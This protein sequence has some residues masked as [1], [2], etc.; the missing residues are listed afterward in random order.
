MAKYKSQRRWPIALVAAAVVLTGGIGYT[1]MSGGDDDDGSTSREPLTVQPASAQSAQVDHVVADADVAEGGL[2]LSV[3]DK[4]K[5]NSKVSF[6]VTWQADG[7]T[8]SGDVDLQAI[9]NKKWQSVKTIAVTDGSGTG[10]AKVPQAGLYRVA[11]GGGDDLDAT[12]SPDV[13][14]LTGGPLESRLVTTVETTDN[15]AV[16]VNAGWMTKS[17]IPIVGDLELQKRGD[18]GWKPQQTVSTDVDGTAIVELKNDPEAEYRFTYGGGD[19]FAE[20]KSNPASLLDSDAQTIPVSDCETDAAIDNLPYGAACHFTPVSS[21]T[22]VVGH[23]YLG[24]AWW[25]TVA[26]GTF[27]ELSGSQEG[28]YEVVDRVMAPARGAELGPASEWTCGDECDVILQT[29]QGNN[30]GF[31]WLRRVET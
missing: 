3:P 12:A 4:V 17:A 10:T 30:T 29:C 23:D 20:T 18:D 8:V 15:G 25:N 13:A 27:I 1:I 6:E 19:K 11:Y 24:N 21:G 5:A 7:R 16:A 9:Q 28:A 26:V 2:R 14:V 22:F 31:T